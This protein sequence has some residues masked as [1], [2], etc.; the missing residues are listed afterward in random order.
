MP[1]AML[2][3]WS[4][5][6]RSKK[7]HGWTMPDWVMKSG[8]PTNPFP[9]F[10]PP[11]WKPIQRMSIKRKSK[12][13]WWIRTSLHEILKVRCNFW[14]RTKT[15]QV[16][17]PIKKWPIIEGL[18]FLLMV[19][20]KGHGNGLINLWKVR[21]IQILKQGH[22]IGKRNLPIDWTDLRKRWWIL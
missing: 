12:N 5:V 8:M 17:K 3:R 11:I 13:F 7:M 10:W 19:I 9:R 22:Y 4:S 16:R 18:N 6:Q 21:K 14:R 1:F 20:M 15:T 2:R